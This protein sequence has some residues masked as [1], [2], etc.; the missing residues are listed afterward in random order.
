MRKHY[1]AGRRFDVM[2]Y[3]SLFLNESAVFLFFFIYRY[4]YEVSD[5][6]LVILFAALGVLTGYLTLHFGRKLKET[7]CYEVTDE[8]LIVSNGRAAR[9]IPWTSFTKADAKMVNVFSRYPVYFTVDGGRFE[10]SQ[11]VEDVAGLGY[12]IMCRM[13]E[14]AAVSERFREMTEAHRRGK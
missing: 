7:L 2:M 10:L 8:A 13:P 14:G 3:L 6:V 4:L 12:D 1:A 9:R 5:A 11:Y